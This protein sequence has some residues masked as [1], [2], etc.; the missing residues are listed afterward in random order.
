M[1]G[2][3]RHFC[4]LLAATLAVAQST[5]TELGRVWDLTQPLSAASPNWE[6]TAVSPFH[7][8]TLGTY[9]TTHYYSRVIT[10]PEHFSTHLD[11][12]AHFA[13]GRWTVEQIPVSHLIAPLI[14]VDVRAQ[15]Q[16]QLRDAANATAD[17][18][19]SLADLAAWES[20][21]GRIPDHAIVVAF[22]GWSSRWNSM[23]RYRNA[24]ARHSMHTPGFSLAAAR[25][26]VDQ[27]HI[28]GLGIDDLS[29]DVG[30]SPDYPVHSYVLDHNVF[31]LENL[32]DLG[33]VPLRGATLVVA[34]AKLVGGSGA[35]VRVFA[36]QR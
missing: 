4:F 27:R 24:D 9:A 17:Y 2:S 7:A 36:I 34:P 33:G 1:L 21:H 8:R 10:L 20:R 35:P 5:A 6:G 11:A 29:L 18:T 26:L 32:A 23:Q 15:V 31:Q 16:A 28:Y 30:A 14:I 13:A 22:T 19:V 3:M 12:P 25:W